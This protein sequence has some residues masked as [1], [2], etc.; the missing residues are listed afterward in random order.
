MFLKVYYWNINYFYN[1]AC[2]LQPL[3]WLTLTY[4]T[5]FLFM[6]LS[7]RN[8]S[9]WC[10]FACKHGLPWPCPTHLFS[11]F[12]WSFVTKIITICTILH[13]DFIFYLTFWIFFFKPT[14]MKF[15]PCVQ[16]WRQILLL[17]YAYI[18]ICVNIDIA[19]LGHNGPLVH[20]LCFC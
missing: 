12:Y 2:W 10:Q 16:L 3:P 1:F 17:T 7:H 6:N 5:V 20:C 8:S 9:Y 14:S 15:V 18:V 4:S 13:V 19:I 11:R